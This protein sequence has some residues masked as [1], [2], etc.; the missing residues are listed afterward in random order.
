MLLMDRQVI[1]LDPSSYRGYEQRHAALHG[2]ERYTEA[3]EAFDTMLLKIEGSPDKHVR[4]ECISSNS[5]GI[6]ER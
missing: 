3:V 4:G 1:K 6:T 5:C 2:A